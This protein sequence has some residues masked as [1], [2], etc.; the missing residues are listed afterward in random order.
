MAV[1]LIA[2]KRGMTRI[3]DEATGSS[4]PVV[5]A[6]V[7]PNRVVQLKTLEQD[8]YTAIQVTTG[9]QKASRLTKPA[10]GHF[11]KSS[12]LPGME[13]MEFTVSPDELQT[14]QV[15][16]EVTVEHFKVGQ[17]ID[18]SGVSKGRGF[19]GVIARHNFSSQR[20][21]HGN[22]LSHNAPGSIGQNQ[23][24]GRVFKG[25]KMAGQYGNARCTVQ[26][27]EVVRIDPKRN[28]ILIKGAVPGAT[29][30]QIVIR[31]AVKL[32]EAVA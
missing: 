9:E 7:S 12:A 15:G 2:T 31:P 25:K 27:L 17:K 18:V 28:L 11:A 21:S 22:S 1:G 8:G 10:A 20:A 6:E 13:L 16:S 5:V 19:A 23:T 14:Y 3:F 32:N 24:P 26:N 4:I 29:G 30:G